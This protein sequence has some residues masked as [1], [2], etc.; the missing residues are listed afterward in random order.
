MLHPKFE[1]K[2]GDIDGNM[3]CLQK[4]LNDMRNELRAHQNYQEHLRKMKIAEEVK[5]IDLKIME[6]Q[7]SLQTLVEAREFLCFPT[8][9][10][11]HSFSAARR[12]YKP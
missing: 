6:H 4:S 3:E 8:E 2:L 10:Q 1:R 11:K 7:E 5:Q 9:K 12:D